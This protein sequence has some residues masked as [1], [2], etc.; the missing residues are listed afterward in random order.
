MKH[1]RILAV[2]I[3]CIGATLANQSALASV[4]S[5]NDT[6]SANFGSGPVGYDTGYLAPNPNS[7][8]VG[9]NVY[10]GG[11]TFTSSNRSYDFSSTGQFNA[12]CVDIYH[13]MLPSYTYTVGTTSDLAAMLA[14][15]R[16]NATERVQQ[17]IQLADE[18][19]GSLSS[20]T[21]SAAF[22][23][24]VWE[25]AY[26][27]PENSGIYQIDSTDPGFMV[28]S[29]T[30]GA[31][32][33]EANGWLSNLNTAAATG[34]YKLTFLNDGTLEDTQD[35]VVFT[36]SIATHDSQTVP[37]PT[38]IALLGLGLASLFG[39]RRKA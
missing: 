32:I 8:T 6:D 30:A 33:T 15:L 23:L 2:V 37:E 3:A 19:Y 28:G 27:T 36:P 39:T 11:D 26:G 10:I 25:I 16:S 7:S 17:L 18:V 5:I 9:V 20:R 35:V 21:D 34:H 24:A 4:I 14:P 12:W 13:W 38:S 29:N 1:E 22:Q 31:A